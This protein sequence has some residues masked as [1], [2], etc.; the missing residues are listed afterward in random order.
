MDMAALEQGL[1]ESDILQWSDA[2]VRFLK[3]LC[4]NTLLALID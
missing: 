2:S 4:K 3:V 1:L